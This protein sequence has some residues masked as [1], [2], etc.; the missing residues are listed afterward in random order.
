MTLLCTSTCLFAIAR[1]SGSRT[2]AVSGQHGSYVSIPLHETSD[3]QSKSAEDKE[4]NYSQTLNSSVLLLLVL[5]ATAALTL[6]IEFHRRILLASEC[7]TRSLEVWLPL[8]LALYD[9]L[10]FQQPLLL[11]DEED[12]DPGSSAY[13]DFARSLRKSLLSSK[14]RYVPAGLLMSLGCHMVAGLWLTSQ[15]SHTCPWVSTDS[16]VV[17]R[18][19]ALCLAIDAFLAIAVAELSSGYRSSGFPLSTPFSWATV[20]SLSAAAWFSISVFVFRTQPENQS[21]L[22][23]NSG[24]PRPTVLFTLLCQ[25]VVLSI[26]CIS[27]LYSVSVR[28]NDTFQYLTS[29]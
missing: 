1:R 26:L 16:F 7:T 8:L 29:F 23:M 15:S 11:E 28:T 4:R 9:A 27:T 19:Q 3:G 21:W 25:A 24:I 22:L 14:Y 5:A 6:R 18:L 10:R 20:T 2:S 13:R 12:D 17:P